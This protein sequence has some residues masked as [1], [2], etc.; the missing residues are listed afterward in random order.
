MQHLAGHSV[1]AR[2]TRGEYRVR[3]I[4]RHNASTSYDGSR[5]DAD[6]SGN[7]R[8]AADPHVRPD[9]DR[10]PELFAPPSLGVEWM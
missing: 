5:S 9:L 3:D 8:S 2:I 10:L 6:A 1:I 4:S 7:D